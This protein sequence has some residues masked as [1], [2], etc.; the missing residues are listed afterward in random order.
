MFLNKKGWHKFLSICLRTAGLCTTD[1]HS[2]LP[3]E[4]RGRA[5]GTEK[6]QSMGLGAQASP[7]DR[8]PSGCLL[9]FPGRHLCLCYHPLV[10]PFFSPDRRLKSSSCTS[11]PRTLLSSFP[12]CCLNSMSSHRQPHHKVIFLPLG[13]LLKDRCEPSCDRLVRTRWIKIRGRLLHVVDKYILS[14]CC[15]LGTPQSRGASGHWV[16]LAK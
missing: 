12:S 9:R 7:E 15:W 5:Q 10:I 3:S 1:T 2:L 16:I 13:T 8:G 14:T 4:T 6:Q 11:L